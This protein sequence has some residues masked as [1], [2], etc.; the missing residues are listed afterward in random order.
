LACGCGAFLRGFVVAYPS[1]HHLAREGGT[2]DGMT[3]LA[4]LLAIGLGC[5]LLVALLKPEW[6]S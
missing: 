2:V 3:W 1:A 5:Y 4:L 6:F